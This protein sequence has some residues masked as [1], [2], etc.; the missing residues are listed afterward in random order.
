MSPSCGS[1]NQNDQSAGLAPAA[2]GFFVRGNGYYD[3]TQAI[4]GRFANMIRL[5]FSAALMIYLTGLNS[6]QIAG[7]TYCK[8][9]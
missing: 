3:P 6:E 4:A 7:L 1:E 9:E 5:P 2:A 8:F